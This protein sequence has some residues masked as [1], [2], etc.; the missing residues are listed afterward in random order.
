MPVYTFR[1][2]KTGEIWDDMMSIS[3]SEKYLSENPD[4]EKD[5]T[6]SFPAMHS[7]IGLGLRKP[8]EGFKDVLSNIKKNN[9]GAKI[10]DHR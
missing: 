10:N 7:G 3:E 1:N 8:D 5:I 6:G 9:K 2:K 4:I